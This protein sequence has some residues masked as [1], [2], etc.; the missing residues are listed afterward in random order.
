MRSRARRASDPVCERGVDL[1][2]ERFELVSPLWLRDQ[3]PCFL[4]RLLQRREPTREAA[5]T[6]SF[7]VQISTG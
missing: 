2:Q 6:M 4:D 7:E 3:L 5:T 1:V